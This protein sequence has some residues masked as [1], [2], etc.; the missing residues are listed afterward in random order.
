MPNGCTKRLGS[1]SKALY[2]SHHPLHTS[3]TVLV[4]LSTTSRSKLYGKQERKSDFPSSFGRWP[5]CV[6][7]SNDSGSHQLSLTMLFEKNHSC[8]QIDSPPNFRL[9]FGI[10]REV[11]F[12][13]FEG[14]FPTFMMGKCARREK[15]LGHVKYVAD[16]LT[17]KYV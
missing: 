16:H 12:R 9:F 11:L 4:Y 7:H 5:V 3:F 1:R 13:P 8:Y 6:G 10:L 14:L 2:T 15:H 17:V